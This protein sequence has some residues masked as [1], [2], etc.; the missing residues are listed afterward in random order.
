MTKL[1]IYVRVSSK[2]QENDGTSIETQINE[3]LEFSKQMGF[4]PVLFNEGGK[5]SWNDSID[6]REK[7]NE[8]FEEIIEGKFNCIWVWNLD[9]LGRNSVS[10]INIHYILVQYKV[11]LY[12]GK[13][14]SPYDLNSEMDELVFKVLTSITTYDNK[15][16]LKRSINGKIQSLKNGQTFVGG[17]IPVGFEVDENKRLQVHPVESEIV[18]E[19][20]RRYKDGE[21]TMDIKVWLNSTTLKPRRSIVWNL[22]SIQKILKN[23]LYIGKQVFEFKKKYPNSID[24]NGKSTKREEV[25]ERVE[26]TVP[27]IIDSKTF[28]KVQK[29]IHDNPQN[30]SNNH[31]S[32]L[33]GIIECGHCG[34]KLG[35]RF[36]GKNNHYY[37]VCTE[38]EW[39]NSDGSNYKHVNHCELKKSLIIEKT[40]NVVSDNVLKIISNSSLVKEEFKKQFLEPKFQEDSVRSKEIRSIKSQIS[41]NLQEIEKLKQSKVRVI[42]QHLIDEVLD[43]ETYDSLILD[44]QNRMNKL[45]NKREELNSRLERMNQYSHWINWIEEMSKQ[46]KNFEKYKLVEKKKLFTEWMKKVVVVWNTDTKEHEFKIKFI[47]PLVEDK[48]EYVDETNKSLGYKILE[49]KKEFRFTQS[50]KNFNQSEKRIELGKKIS[51]LKNLGYSLGKIVD[52]LN[53]K[54][55]KSLRGKPWT[56]GGISR[57]MKDLEGSLN[58]PK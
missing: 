41:T 17:T 33:K 43:K 27:P 3:G 45:E 2:V 7:L 49:G 44:I 1:G 51:E 13:S 35:H 6:E 53:K 57:F 5:T 10:W 20:Y 19:I 50:G 12:V 26:I 28:E 21:S 30:T 22:G 29:K 56:R 58:S 9:R 8:M 37:G 24:K 40:D 15:L 55:V 38:R 25:F 16:R 14:S 31:K 36:K 18:K 42:S 23:P 39:K 47:L 34:R 46:F 4:E 54:G 32:L 11:N 48:L 52:E